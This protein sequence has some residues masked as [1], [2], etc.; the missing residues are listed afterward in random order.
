MPPPGWQSVRDEALARIRSGL[1]APGARIPDEADLARE[2]GVARTTVNRALRDLAATGLLERRRRGGTRVAPVPVRRASFAIPVIR[3][4]VEDRGMTHGYVLLSRAT[5]PAPA[6]VARADGLPSAA[7]VEHVVAL[8]SADGV[9]FCHEERWINPAAVPGLASADFATESAN[10]WLVRTV[11]VTSG[12]LEIAAAP[13][14]RAAARALGCPPGT[15]VLTLDRTTRSDRGPVTVA[16]LSYA[17]GHR[18]RTTL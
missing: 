18:L 15:P 5:V 1:W 14:S 4:D 9:P 7:P 12:T 17:P 13:A 16:R 10:E 11:P 3:Q 8:H 2:L 6:A